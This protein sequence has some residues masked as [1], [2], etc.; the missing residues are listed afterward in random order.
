MKRILFVLVSFMICLSGFSQACHRCSAR[1]KINFAESHVSNYGVG[2]VYMKCPVCSQTIN[3]NDGP[4]HYHECPSCKGTGR[5]S[6]HGS[7]SNDA[8]YNGCLTVDENIMVN[9]L[10]RA[11]FEPV[12]ETRTCHVCKGAGH[13]PGTGAHHYGNMAAYVFADVMPAF[14]VMC[15][16]GGACPNRDCSG[17]KEYYTRPKTDSEKE[18]Y[19]RKIQEIYNNAWKR[20]CGFLSSGSSSNNSS[21][22]NS[23]SNSTINNLRGTRFLNPQKR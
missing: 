14:C 4:A 9:E 21:T 19:L 6:G 13:C 16:G 12:T 18:V 23:N 17:G 15:G 1:G 11:M 20:E 3:I 10:M 2:P 8:V 7:G 22:S 5:M